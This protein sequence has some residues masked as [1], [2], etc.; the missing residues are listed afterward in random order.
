MSCVSSSITNVALKGGG[1]FPSAF[2]FPSLKLW[3]VMLFMHYETEHFFL[4]F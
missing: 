1:G 3:E 2:C 4:H